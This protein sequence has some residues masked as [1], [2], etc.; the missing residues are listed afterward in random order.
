MKRIY[1]D[2]NDL[3]KLYNSGMSGEQLANHFGVGKTTICRRLAEIG[4]H[5]ERVRGIDIQKLIR[6]YNS[7]MSINQLARR[8]HTTRRTIDKRL[9]DNG[10]VTRTPS[11]AMYVRMR[12]TTA[13]ERA[14]MVKAAHA[15]ARGR[16]QSFEELCRHSAGREAVAK[17]GSRIEEI[18]RN[19]LELRGFGTVPQKAI[20]PY[21]IDIALTEYPI[22]VEIFG[23]NWHASGDHAVRFKERVKYILDSGWHIVIIWVI[24]DYP[25]EVG[26]I[27][28]IVS[29]AELISSGE[30]E[31]CQEHM[32]RG[33]GQFHAIG[34]Y[35]LHDIPVKPG[36]Q[37]RDN[38][39]G[40][41]IS[42]IG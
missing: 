7:G 12:Q 18:C 14:R 22:A 20:G 26:A 39:T 37:P 13:E 35:K 3:L 10:I 15:A 30:A 17:S 9:K 24:R 11:E 28:Y 4:I 33:D 36:P 6:L 32:I 41:F 25:L 29:L 8:F 34:Y 21:N 31:R 38:S 16:R 19:E 27:D 1:I 23:G 5:I 42:R 40:R 2:I